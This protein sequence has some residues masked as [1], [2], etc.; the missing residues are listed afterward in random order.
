[1]LVRYIKGKYT[2]GVYILMY[3]SMSLVGEETNNLIQKFKVT[4]NELSKVLNNNIIKQYSCRTRYR[5][6]AKDTSLSLYNWFFI[7]RSWEVHQSYK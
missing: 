4:V 6:I 7:I 1:M 5:A 3:I 2:S